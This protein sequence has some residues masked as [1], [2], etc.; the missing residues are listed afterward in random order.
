MMMGLLKIVGGVAGFVVLLVIVNTFSAPPVTAVQRGYRGTGMVQFYQPAAYRVAADLNK[1]PAPED[2]VDP[3]GQK[4][5]EVYQNVKVLGDVDANEFIRLMAAITNWVSPNEGCAYCHTDNPAEDTLYT[6]VVARRML[7]MT[8]YINT[9]WKNH[10]AAT[11]V[12]CYTCHRGNPVPKNIWF[13][14][15]DPPHPAGFAQAPTGK[16][17]A[18]PV[19][20]ST[21]LPNQVFTPF[22]EDKQN[23]RVIGETALPETTQHTI[24]QTEWTYGLMIHFSESLGVNCTY[25][26]NTRSFFAWDQSSPARGTAWY[27]IRMA[28]SVNVDYLDPLAS[29]FPKN[30]L[31]PHGDSP[32]VNCL[33]C[34]QGVY[35]PLFGNSMLG[36]YPEL[37]ASK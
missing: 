6:K 27:G 32:K 15:V 16:N 5:S 34:H 31:G 18:S 21:S 36:D 30:R 33:T 22:L 20:G 3:A 19:V 23:I 14:E 26:H 12:T 10:V 4:S 28:R 13:N 24:K 17:I 2:K 25:C 8:K 29:V 1:V 37:A 35:K 9:N 11:G 7:Q